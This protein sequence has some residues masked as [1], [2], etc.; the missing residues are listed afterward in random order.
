[1]MM[2]LKARENSTTYYFKC[3][4]SKTVKSAPGT[5]SLLQKVLTVVLTHSA[6]DISGGIFG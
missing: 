2:Q 3:F 1:M 6:L 4:A 5:R